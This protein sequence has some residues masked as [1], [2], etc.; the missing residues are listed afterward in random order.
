M[1]CS[2]FVTCSNPHVDRYLNPLPWDPLTSPY[3]ND[4]DAGTD[5]DA[6]FSTGADAN[7]HAHTSTNASTKTDHQSWSYII[8]V[9]SQSEINDSS[10]SCRCALIGVPCRLSMLSTFSTFANV[11]F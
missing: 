8:L 11:L 4:T 2:Q 3:T 1:R 9:L 6:K 10:G 5:T 7:S